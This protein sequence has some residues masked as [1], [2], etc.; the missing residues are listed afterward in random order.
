MAGSGKIH[1][2]N[3]QTLTMMLYLR[4]FRIQKV[5][6]IFLWIQLLDSGEEQEIGNNI[7]SKIHF[8]LMILNN[9][10]IIFILVDYFYHD[11][12]GGYEILVMS[13]GGS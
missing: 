11:E 5:T 13:E 12:G 6:M 3:D 10:Y 8:I 1:M 7:I 4:Q 2:H 9:M